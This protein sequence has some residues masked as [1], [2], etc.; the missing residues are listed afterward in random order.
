MLVATKQAGLVLLVAVSTSAPSNRLVGQERGGPIDVFL[1]FVREEVRKS[2]PPKMNPYTIRRMFLRVIPEARGSAIGSLDKQKLDRLGVTLLD[3]TTSILV[4][5]R[6]GSTGSYVRDDGMYVVVS[7]AHRVDRGG[8]AIT[9]SSFVTHRRPNEKPM[10]CLEEKRVELRPG[11]AGGNWE[12][13]KS[14]EHWALLMGGV[15]R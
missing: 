2:V 11:S 4:H 9:Y 5:D 6:A 8:L 7:S 15:T 13:R 14:A 10:V 3:D 12:I 1:I